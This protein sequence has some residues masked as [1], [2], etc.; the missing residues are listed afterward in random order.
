MKQSTLA[1]LLATLAALAFYGAG[2]MISDI[3]SPIRQ[4]L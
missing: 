4:Y 2:A 1:K 3:V